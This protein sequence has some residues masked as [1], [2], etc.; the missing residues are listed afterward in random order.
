MPV[1]VIV[2]WPTAA[3]E[4]ALNVRLWDT[5]GVSVRVDGLAVTPAGNA[6]KEML[7]FDV[8]PF[9]AVAVRETV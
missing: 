8:N 4:P 7:T 1:N 3:S 5:P 6:L 9:S 2:D